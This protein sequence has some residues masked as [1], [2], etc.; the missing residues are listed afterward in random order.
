[1][2][3][4]L[5]QGLT[6][7]LLCWSFEFIGAQQIGANISFDSKEHDFGKINEE[8][9]PVTHKF[10]FINTGNSPLIINKV[11]ASCGCTT[12]DYTKSPVPP[13]GKGFVSATFNPKNRPGSFT[14]NVTI[15]SNSE[16]SAMVLVIKGEVVSKPLSN[17]ESSYNFN[18]GELSASVNSLAFSKLDYRLTKTLSFNV[19]NQSNNAL[20]VTFKKV[21]NHLKVRAIPD[22][23]QAHGKGKIE[24][25]YDA[26]LKNDWG[27]SSDKVG[28]V[29]NGKVQ[30][31]VFFT[32]TADI[33]EDYSKLSP[34]EIS[35]A[36]QIKFVETTY[37]FGAVKQ[38]SKVIH[39]FFFKNTGKS[40]LIIRKL[41]PSPGGI[42]TDLKGKIIKAGQDGSFKVTFDISGKEDD[43]TKS[44]TVTTNDPKN[45][46][47]IVWL[48]GS[49]IK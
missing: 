14:K 3:R 46:S 10:D 31:E 17:D 22:V 42:I 25:T 15:T 12:P 18:L 40:D 29:I 41:K 44:I 38:G 27:Y 47:V 8:A 11:E 21:P 6:V 49:I 36:A 39:E 4:I 23:I 16:P 19:S 24:V 33:I 43:Q 48:K 9:G 20:N 1:M 5:T 32:V 13:G 7:I 30:Q 2:N 26:K 45:S 28:V 35:N 34:L 37:N